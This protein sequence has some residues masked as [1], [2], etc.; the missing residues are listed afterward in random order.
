MSL[1]VVKERRSEPESQLTRRAFLGQVTT[2]C[3]GSA[4]LSSGCRPR[5]R[6]EP[7]RVGI[8]HSQTGTMAISE[9]SLRDIE[10][11]AIEEINATGG[12]LGRMIEPIV[13]DPR[14]RFDDLFP[15][16]RA[17]IVGRRRSGRRVRML[18]V[19]KPQGRVAGF[20]R[21][22]WVALL[23]VAVRGERVLSE[24][25]LYGLSPESAGA[26]GPRLAP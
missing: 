7:I 26:S 24:H 4:I 3:A 1:N 14:S 9:T 17:E 10:L 23:S 15:E 20:R 8:L 19:G 12:V 6:A 25:H 11:F 13:E 18:D 5:V 2:A 22:E 16:T 21:V